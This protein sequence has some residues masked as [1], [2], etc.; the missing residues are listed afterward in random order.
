M[1]SEKRAGE[2]RQRAVRVSWH[3]P[4]SHRHHVAPNHDNAMV[5]FELIPPENVSADSGLLMTWHGLLGSSSNLY[6]QYQSPVWWEHLGTTPEAADRRLLIA[7]IGSD[8]A[9]VIPLQLV[10]RTIDTNLPAVLQDLCAIR[11]AELL[12]SLPLIPADAGVAVAMLDAVLEHVPEAQAVYFKSI[13]RTSPWAGLIMEAGSASRHGFGYVSRETAFH[14]LE[15]PAKFDEYLGQFGKKKRYNL[16]RQV[17][18]MEDAYGGEMHADCI[19]RED[20]IEFFLATAGIVAEGSWKDDR[21]TAAFA[22]TASNHHR[23]ADLARRGLLRG[24]LLRH[25]ERPVASVLG[26]QFENTY[27]YADIA[28]VQSDVHLSPGS[29]LLYLIIR[30]LIENT[31][32]RSVNFGMGDADYKRQF[33]NQHDRDRACWVMRASPRNRVIC[34]AHGTAKRLSQR[35]GALRARGGKGESPEGEEAY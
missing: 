23:Y 18:L 31:A 13:P 28:Y 11:C 32:V 4:V 34:A 19:I 1:G 8:I 25:G 33:G 22:R 35:L 12:G 29:V 6:A 16:K 14:S 9:G 21:H 27:H 10:V 3:A 5:A 30:D 7:K 17:R 26:F 15:L 24:Y 20:Q 2:G